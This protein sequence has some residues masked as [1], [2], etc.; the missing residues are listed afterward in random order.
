MAAHHDSTPDRRERNGSK[1]EDQ[2]AEEQ[3]RSRSPGNHQSPH[4][5]RIRNA[6]LLTCG[7]LRAKASI[8]V[9]SMHS[10]HAVQQHVL[11]RIMPKKGDLPAAMKL[12]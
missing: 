8:I 7:L 2:E 4:S 9:G 5:Y 12:R 10:S 3:A 11:L 1:G 6:F